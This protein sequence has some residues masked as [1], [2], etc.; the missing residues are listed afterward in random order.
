MRIYTNR[1]WSLS[2]LRLDVHLG[3]EHRVNITEDGRQALLDLAHGDM[4]RVINIMQS[5]SM[6]FDEVNEEHVYTCVGHPLKSDIANVVTWM[7]N[8]DFTTAYSKVRDLQTLKGLALQ[9]VLTEVHHFVHRSKASPPV[10]TGSKE[11]R[12]I[13]VEIG[14]GSASQLEAEVF[15]GGLRNQILLILLSQLKNVLNRHFNVIGSQCH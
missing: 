10:F 6:A 15:F 12:L 5:T 11:T 13:R 4:R 9:D 14:P 7:L 8:D 1:S 2:I 3:N